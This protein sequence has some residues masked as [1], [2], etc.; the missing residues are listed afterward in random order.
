MTIWHKENYACSFMIFWAKEGTDS[1]WQVLFIWNVAVGCVM[2]IF[3]MM[4]R[5]R[6]EYMACCTYVSLDYVFRE[7]IYHIQQGLQP[8]TGNLCK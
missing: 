6:N 8:R 1:D 3:A 7:E 2:S 5:L 4:T